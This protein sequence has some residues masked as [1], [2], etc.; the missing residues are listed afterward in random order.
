MSNERPLALSLAHEILDKEEF[1]H[2]RPLA[3]EYLKDVAR[4]RAPLTYALMYHDA[5][6]G[7]LRESGPA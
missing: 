2:L 3:R 1:A 4:D 6:N 7:G 5:P